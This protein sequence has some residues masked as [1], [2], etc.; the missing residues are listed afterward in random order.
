MLMIN[1]RQHYSLHL[2]YIM[3]ICSNVLILN[4]LSA[5]EITKIGHNKLSLQIP[6]GDMY[7][8]LID[9]NEHIEA[10]HSIN[11]HAR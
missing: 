11:V 6:Y 4:F 1:G 7:N 10:N 8:F 2:N 9:G 3:M 5:T